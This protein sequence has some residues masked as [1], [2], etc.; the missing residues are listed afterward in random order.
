[1][2][3][4]KQRQAE[5]RATAHGTYDDHGLVV[6]TDI[7]TPVD[8][9]NFTARFHMLREA[10]GLR[11][12]RLHDVRHAHAS[13]MLRAGVEMIVVSRRLGHEDEAFT[14]RTYRHVTPDQQ[15]SAVSRLDEFMARKVAGGHRPETNVSAVSANG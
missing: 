11:R 13:S 8:P 4:T 14:M 5:T 12:I 3:M 6:A 2:H 10:A 7:G 15:E 9:D 1:M